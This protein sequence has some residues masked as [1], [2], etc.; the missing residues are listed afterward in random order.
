MISWLRSLVNRRNEL[1]LNILDINYSDL[2]PDH[3][4]IQQLFNTEIDGVFIRGVFS[5]EEIDKVKTKLNS[6]DKSSIDQMGAHILEGFVIPKAFPVVVMEQRETGESGSLDAYFLGCEKL[7]TEGA[8]LFGIDL[9]GKIQSVLSSISRSPL[10]IV[11]GMNGVGNYPFGTIR[12][13]V[14]GPGNISVHC[15]N[16]FQKAFPEFYEELEKS[17][18]VKNQ[19]SYTIKLQNEDEGGDLTLYDLFWSETQTK[20]DAA[21]NKII[22]DGDRRIDIDDLS[23]SRISLNYNEGDMFVFAGGRIWHRVES[24]KGETTRM[25]IGGFIGKSKGTKEYK[26]WA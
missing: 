1:K 4:F 26:Y 14:P 20:A 17:V 16:Y 8:S 15:G 7:V 21:E 25:T 9:S 22:T 11:R 5:K 24:V 23:L 13:F 19:L 2:K 10:S 6:I 18:E 3:D 12:A